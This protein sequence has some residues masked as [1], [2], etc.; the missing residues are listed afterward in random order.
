VPPAPVGDE[1]EPAADAIGEMK[2]KLA[3]VGYGVTPG[4]FLEEETR[5]VVAAFQ[6][7]FRPARID[8]RADASTRATLDRLVA[9]LDGQPIS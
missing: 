1:A 7:R 6:R 2:A 3:R 8:G 4:S 9:V 5:A